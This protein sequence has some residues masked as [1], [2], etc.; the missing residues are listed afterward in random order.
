MAFLP[1]D[2]FFEEELATAYDLTTGLTTFT[3]SDISAYSVI[4]IQFIYANI[5]GSN[6]FVIEQ[7]TEGNNFWSNVSP[8]Y[9][10]PVGN[11]N[12][13]IDKSVFTGKYIRVDL[14]ST[15]S[16]ELTIKLL[17]KR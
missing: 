15:S 6:L 9:E 17:A 16:G 7:S 10:I 8:Q 11:G 2:N 4:S 13:I 5:D 1:E 12:F 14:Q 3:S